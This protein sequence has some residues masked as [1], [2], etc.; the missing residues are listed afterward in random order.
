MEKSLK[1]TVNSISL[2]Y[3]NFN[4]FSSSKGWVGYFEKSGD[5]SLEIVEESI[6]LIERF[7]SP[8]RDDLFVISA[9]SYDDKREDDEKII[10]TYGPIYEMA[11]AQKFLLPMKEEFEKYLYGESN[12]TASCLSLHFNDKDNFLDICRL[13]MTH[14]GVLG[15]VFFLI[16]MESVFAIY[17]HEEQGFGFIELSSSTVCTDFLKS[18]E[19]NN[20]F[21]VYHSY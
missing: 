4:S 3:L 13:L 16:N 17:P 19:N 1:L 9:L 10:H 14:G 8:H 20:M 21:N 15:S 7:L 6:K 11:K 12:L 2:D 5:F 18:I